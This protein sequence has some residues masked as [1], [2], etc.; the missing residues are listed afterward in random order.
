MSLLIPI[1]DLNPHRRFPVITLLLIAA[2]VVAFIAT[3]RSI[4][5]GI[6]PEA[7]FHYGAVPCDVLSRCAQLSLELDT[8]FPGRSPFISLFTSMFMHADI[9]HIGF[10]M[11]FLWVFGN[12]VEDRL[13]R[14]RFPI[15]YVVTGLAASFAQI[16]VSPS[17]PVPTIGAS[18]A[19]SGLLGAYVILWPRATIISLVPLGFFF[20][21]VRTPAWVSLGLWFVVQIFGG[22][23]GLGLSEQTGG[24]AFLAHVGGFVAGMFLIV[25]FGG[26][27][28]EPHG[29][30]V[31][32][33][34][35]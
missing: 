26:R 10:N 19:I 5:G 8:E 12:N 17:A 2:N 25:P 27:R 6:S 4:L 1:R 16:L 30:A 9:L 22:L 3:S 15:F 20:F 7:A 24:V 33:P 31:D 32:D 28:T 29:L 34:Y 21:S 11:L 18:G 23:A 14:I 13:G 35:D